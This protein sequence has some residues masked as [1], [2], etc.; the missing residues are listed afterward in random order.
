MYDVRVDSCVVNHRVIMS[1]S[2]NFYYQ[3]NNIALR[4][5]QVTLLIVKMIHFSIAARHSSVYPPAGAPSCPPCKL[6]AFPS[7]GS[8][9]GH[10]TSS[11]FR[12]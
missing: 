4:A 10:L 2:V 3:G 6:L 11:N 5:I 7:S 1:V 9:H 12:K 8:G